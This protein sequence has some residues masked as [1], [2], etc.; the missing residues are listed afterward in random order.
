MKLKFLIAVM[1][2]KQAHLEGLQSSE[3]FLRKF[4]FVISELFKKACDTAVANKRR[5]L[6]ARDV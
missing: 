1:V 5:T 6:L 3:Q 4:D 2:R